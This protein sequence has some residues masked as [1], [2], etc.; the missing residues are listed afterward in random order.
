MDKRIISTALLAMVFA[1]FV[2]ACNGKN[3]PNPE[4]INPADKFEKKHDTAVLLVTFG[5][6]YEVPKATYASQKELFQKAFP[7]SDLYYSYTSRTIINRLEA[8]GETFIQPPLWFQSFLKKKYKNVYV[9]SLH[10]IPGEE[11]TLLRDAYVKKEYNKQLF[12]LKEDKHMKEYQD[13]NY[14]VLGDPLL[15]DDASIEHVAKFL[16]D[17]YAKELK[18]GEVVA[19]MGHGNPEDNYLYANEKYNVIEKKMQ[20]Y[21]TK[22]YRN[23]RVFVATVDFPGKL[24]GDYLAGAVEQCGAKEKIINLHPLM[25][26]AG[27]HANN[28][29]A[30]DDTME[31]G[32]PIPMEERSWKLQLQNMGWTVKAT[33]K[34]LGDYPEINQIY[35]EHLKRAIADAGKED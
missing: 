24:F 34:G 10:V 7:N 27:D 21:A 19:F 31:A 23:G 26:I 29:M 16:V 8:Q 14:A 1:F 22:Q 28:D 3:E 30:G 12:D 18:A 2:S 20:E 33:I 32:Q 4:N 6:T 9:Q 15:Y 13:C 25:T 11:Y 5:S 17:L 35:L